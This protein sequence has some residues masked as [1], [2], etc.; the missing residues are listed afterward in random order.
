M[1]VQ[2]AAADR[3]RFDLGW[4]D[5]RHTFSFGD[6]HDPRHMHFRS[7]RVINEDRVAPG[8]GFPTHP[9]RDMEIVTYVLAGAIEHKDCMG[10]GSVIVPGDVQRM[11]AGTGITH[12]EYNPSSA[13]TLHLLQIWILPERKGLSP[14]YEQKRFADQEKSGRLRL[15]A[16]RDG[17]QGSLTLHQDVNLYASLLANDE[18][19][20]HQLDLGRFGWLQLAR[21]SVSLNEVELEA[22][23]GAAISGESAL[24][25]R[26]REPAELLLFDLG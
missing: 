25:I 23:D 18:E 26:A 1:I 24:R 5:T 12:S 19:I 17:R 7:L 20:T 22:G 10:N 16:S 15:V 21:G 14:G 8:G 3:G 2:R 6:Y 9:H 11:S 13:E 4:L